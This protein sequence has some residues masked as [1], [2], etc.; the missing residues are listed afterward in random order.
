MSLRTVSNYLNP[1]SV[2][3]SQFKLTNRY[4]SNPIS[5]GV[6]SVKYESAPRQGATVPVTD[7]NGQ[8]LLAGYMPPGLVLD[9]LG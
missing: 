3:A 7:N 8:P 9:C 1:A 5:S 4:S 2:Q 6:A